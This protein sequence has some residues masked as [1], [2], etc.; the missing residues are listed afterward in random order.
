MLVSPH[1]RLRCQRSGILIMW[2]L[3]YSDLGSAHNILHPRAHW[4]EDVGNHYVLVRRRRRIDIDQLPHSL[5]KPGVPADVDLSPV[6][7]YSS[8][9]SV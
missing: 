8:A 6:A 7:K 1:I 3:G 5:S 9:M 4:L 2:H